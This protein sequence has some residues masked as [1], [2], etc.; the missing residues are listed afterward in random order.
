MEWLSR[1]RS[2]T[3]GLDTAPLIYFIEDNR[4]YREII[5]SFFEDLDRGEFSVITS[6]LTLTEV[7][8][9]PLRSGNHRLATRY[10]DILLNQNNLL[11]VPITVEIAEI[12]AE[13]RARYQIR[14]PDAL[15]IAAALDKNVQF[16][17]TNDKRLSSIK[18]LEAL[19]L[20]ALLEQE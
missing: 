9:H 19:V 20:D 5:H 7:M 4:K 2:K 12:A 15:Q 17:L 3:V 6:T 1:I 14:T 18:E 10:R 11:V 13:L 8:V 16:F